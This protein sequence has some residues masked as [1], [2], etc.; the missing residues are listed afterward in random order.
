MTG[1]I[2]INA[3]FGP[4]ARPDFDAPLATLREQAARHGVT[5]SLA[6]DLGAL[7]ADPIGGNNRALEIAADPANHLSAV[8]VI[9]ANRLDLTT[10]SGLDVRDLVRRGAKAVRLGLGSREWHTGTPEIGLRSAATRTVL[11]QVARAG[12]PLMIP[13][14][15]WGDATTAG[16]VT[17][18]LGIPVVLVDIHYIAIIDNIEALRRFPHLSIDISRLATFRAIEDLVREIGHERVFLGSENPDRCLASPVNAVLAAEIPDDA[19]RAILRDNAVR[20]FGL[21]APERPLELRPPTLPT[22]PGGAF[23]V[24]CHYN[25]SPWPVPQIGD[26]EIAPALGRLGTGGNVAS[27]AVGILSD[28]GRRQFPGPGVGQPANRP[29]HVRRRRPVGLRPGAGGVE[30]QHRRRRRH[31]R[32]GPRRVRG[33]ADRGPA[34]RRPV[35]DPR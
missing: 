4:R 23:D 22:L 1:F 3:R 28:V 31:R 34:H 11:E 6:F 33:D 26:H 5:H 7:H 2:D 9:P 18:D 19:K 10:G 8:A 17:K 15:G 20:L 16:E 13:V 30:A 32:Q 27:P 12:V 25:P 29:V 35:R 21:P 24:H 14:V